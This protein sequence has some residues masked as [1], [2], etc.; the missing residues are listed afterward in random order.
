MNTSATRAYL[1]VTSRGRIL[2]MMIL[3]VPYVGVSRH[4][5]DPHVWQKK[6]GTVAPR[7]AFLAYDLYLPLCLNCSSFA[8][9]LYSGCHQQSGGSP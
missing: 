4:T 8:S 2:P 1:L 9:R 3:A 6:L 7:P 5:V